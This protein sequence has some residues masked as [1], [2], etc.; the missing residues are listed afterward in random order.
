MLAEDEYPFDVVLVMELLLAFEATKNALAQAKERA[1]QA[2]TA[3]LSAARPAQDELLRL[4]ALLRR[5]RA[6]RD[7]A[8]P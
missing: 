2:V 5:D 6:I 8:P 1:Q 7:R 4:D 3:M